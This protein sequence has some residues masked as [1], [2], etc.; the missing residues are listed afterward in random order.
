MGNQI[1]NIGESAFYDCI[2]LTGLISRETVANIGETA[3]YH[4]R[5]MTLGVHP[6]SVAERYAQ[7]NKLKYEHIQ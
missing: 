2:M 6:G 3:F 5:G 7:E 4:R 1:I